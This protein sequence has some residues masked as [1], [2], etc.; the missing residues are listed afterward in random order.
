MWWEK[1][2]GNYTQK[3]YKRQTPPSVQEIVEIAWKETDSFA[4]YKRVQNLVR[5]AIR[6]ADGGDV[7]RNSKRRG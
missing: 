6:I 5:R 4:S 1:V 7:G 3:D 2:Y